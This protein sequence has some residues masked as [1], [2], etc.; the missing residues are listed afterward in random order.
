MLLVDRVEA[1]HLARQVEAE[2]VLVAVAVDD[3]GLDRAGAHRGDRVERIAFAEHVVARVQRADVLDQHVQVH[4]RALVH[5]L[6][7][8]GLRERAGAAEMQRVAVVGEYAPVDARERGVA[9]ARHRALRS[10]ARTRGRGGVGGLVEVAVE[11]HG[12]ITQQ[13]PTPRGGE[14]A[15]RLDART[16]PSAASGASCASASAKYASKSMP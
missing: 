2:H 10:R 16:S 4:Q 12:D 15:A 11:A 13:Q 3:V 1:D 9:H 5:A 6:R 7:Q 8:A 14:D